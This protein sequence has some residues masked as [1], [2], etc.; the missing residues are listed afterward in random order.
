MKI[1]YYRDGS[2]RQPVYEGFKSIQKK[3]R[4]TW[5]KFYQLQIM[6]KENGKVIHSGELQV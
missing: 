1:H 5:R 4:I 6:L 2:G 3:V